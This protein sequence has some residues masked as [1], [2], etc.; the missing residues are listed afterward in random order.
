MPQTIEM[1]LYQQDYIYILYKQGSSGRLR[2]WYC[3]NRFTLSITSSPT[4]WQKANPTT[5]LL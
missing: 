5:V 1:K 3:W 2:R 4:T